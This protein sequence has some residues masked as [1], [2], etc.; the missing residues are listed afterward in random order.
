MTELSAILRLEGTSRQKASG[1]EVEV[2][3]SNPATARKAFLLFKQ[4]LGPR[5]LDVRRVQRRAGRRAY[6]VRISQATGSEKELLKAA[7]LGFAAEDL[8]VPKRLCCRRSLLRAVLLC[9]GSIADPER[10]NHLE[11]PLSAAAA[12]YIKECLEQLGIHPGSMRRK[13]GPVLYIKDGETIVEFLG[14]IGAHNA[15]LKLENIRISKDVRNSINRLVNCETA[16]VDKTVNAAMQQV[17]AI[18]RVDKQLGLGGLSPKLQEVAMLRAKHPYASLQELA[19]LTS[20][21]VSRSTVQYRLRRLMEIAEDLP[22][23]A[24]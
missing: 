15:L 6:S 23:V 2:T 4:L 18:R 22:H 17:E 8:L 3:L 1:W 11:I 7:E 12:P 10:Q 24:T 19:E 14:Q 20:P 13:S 9:R 5:E 21:R 16:N